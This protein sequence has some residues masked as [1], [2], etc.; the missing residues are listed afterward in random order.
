MIIQ[1]ISSLNS[2][3]KQKINFS[4]ANL[5]QDGVYK[6]TD[7]N[8][9]KEEAKKILKKTYLKGVLT[10]IVFLVLASG[11]ERL[12]EYLIKKNSTKIR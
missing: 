1:S 4:S 9:D 8:N 2:L 11:G 7:S 3:N 5:N 12:C 10:G 6:P